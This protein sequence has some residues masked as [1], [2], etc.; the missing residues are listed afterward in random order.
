MIKIENNTQQPKKIIQEQIK[1]G[2]NKYLD[3]TFIRANE[4][5]DAAVDTFKRYYHSYVNKKSVSSL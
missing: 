5:S 2:K 1:I 4:P 3:V